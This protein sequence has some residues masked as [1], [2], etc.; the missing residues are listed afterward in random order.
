MT[1]AT[2]RQKPFTRSRI[3]ALVIIGLAV[4]GLAYLR[5]AP[6]AGPVSVPNGAHAG[7]LILESLYVRHRGR[8]LRRRLRDARRSREPGRP[9]VA[10]DRAAGDPDPRHV[11]PPG[12]SRSSGSRAARASPTCSSRARAGSPPTTTS[13]SSAT[14]ASTAPS[15]STA[16]RSSRR[17]ST[18]R[19]SSTRRPSARTP[20][21][22]AR[23]RHACTAEGVDLAGYSLPQRVDDLEAAR[24][25]LGYDR[26]DLLSESAGTRTAMIYAWRY[27]QSIHRSVMIG[28]NPP[29]HFLWDAKTT[30]E[31]IRRYAALCAQ[32]DSCRAGRPTSPPRSTRP[33]RTS[34]SAGCSSRSRRATSRRRVLRPDGRDHRRRRTARRPR[35]RSTR[36]SPPS[37]ATAAA[38]GSSR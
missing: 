16:P 19:T 33:R 28:V 31:Q 18:R 5:F 24:K 29:G 27:P 32:D 37:R 34:R 35:G 17:S 6:D 8:W 11:G 20:T 9:G 36:C 13:S 23:A 38:R 7:D 30:G 3:V 22:S 25:A 21:R 15:G 26:I 12:A 2:D 10:A 4:L 1:A 14:A